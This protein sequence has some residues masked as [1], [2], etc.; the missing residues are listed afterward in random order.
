MLPGYPSGNGQVMWQ[1]INSRELQEYLTQTDSP[2]VLLDLRPT[3]QFSQGHLPQAVNVPLNSLAQELFDLDPE[4]TYI[5]ICYSGSKARQAAALL[6][7]YGVQQVGVLLGGM[8]GW[9]G[10]LTR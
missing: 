3:Y 8:D 2:P 9:E 7:E 6:L 5:T 10:P 4:R 1:E